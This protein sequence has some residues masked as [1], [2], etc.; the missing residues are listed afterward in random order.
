MVYSK[1]KHA[2]IKLI[3]KKYLNN[4]RRLKDILISFTLA[5]KKAR[6]LNATPEPQATTSVWA[7]RAC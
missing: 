5:T 7:M 2:L 1:F 3:L 4:L 6:M